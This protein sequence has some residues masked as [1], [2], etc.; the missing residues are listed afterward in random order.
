MFFIKFLFFCQIL[1]LIF[2]FSSPI[3]LNNQRILVES[4]ENNKNEDGSFKIKL[5]RMELNKIEEETGQSKIEI[6]Y[7]IDEKN[8]K[9]CVYTSVYTN[10]CDNF[11][12]VLHR[13][14]SI[15]NG[16][17]GKKIILIEESFY[18]LKRFGLSICLKESNG[19]E[20][21]VK[22]NTFL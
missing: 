21:K 13:V 19:T 15:I 1:F 5:L 10:N 20:Q 3:L 4:T 18:D 2:P 6:L 16:N 7:E 22:L 17:K 12:F 8:E 9:D 14:K 11:T